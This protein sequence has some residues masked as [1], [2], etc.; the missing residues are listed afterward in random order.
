MFA[1]HVKY[2][3][4]KLMSNKK[5]NA[6]MAKYSNQVHQ[7]SDYAK[8]KTLPG[9]RNKNPLHLTRLMNAMKE[10]YL[11]SP[12]IV[13]QYYDVID[14]QHRLHCCKELGLP[15]YY[16][17]C[18]DYG[19]EEVQIL[20]ANASNWTADNYMEGYCDL[21]NSEYIKYRA[22]KNK[23]GF[24]HAITITLLGGKNAMGGRSDEMAN[25]K[26][27]KFK[28]ASYQTAVD[29]ADK[30]L[31]IEPY[32]PDFK[33]QKF[34]ITIIDLIRKEVFNFIEFL[35]K[36]KLQPTALQKC[37][38]QEQYKL[39]IEEIYNYRRREKVNLRF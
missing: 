24:D 33:Q 23:Y 32:F 27:G 2:Y 30:V 21:G 16:I 28:I 6:P 25:F 31:M 19:L 10:R 7:T 14:G 9:N 4:Q 22:F 15:V 11:F 39:L 1:E 36:L 12:I 34:I 29:M 20:N 35:S 38:T 5:E 13:N 17:I 8:F 26:N 3:Y 18:K 37:A